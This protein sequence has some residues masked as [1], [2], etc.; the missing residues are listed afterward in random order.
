MKEYEELKLEVLVF[1]K[2]DI[3]VTSE[4]SSEPGSHGHDTPEFPF[5]P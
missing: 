3:I 2:T 4:S 1:E 5:E